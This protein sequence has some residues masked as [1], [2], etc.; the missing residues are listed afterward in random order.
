MATQNERVHLVAEAY[1]TSPSTKDYEIR[2]TKITPVC[3]DGVIQGFEQCD[4]QSSADPGCSASCTIEAG[5][6]CWGVPST[7]IPL[8][9]TGSADSCTEPGVSTGGSIVAVGTDF[10]ADFSDTLDLG[11]TGCTT[12]SGS[13]EAVFEVAR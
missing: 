8:S 5:Y 1:S 13:P 7:C 10:F 11:G 3:G 2:V 4:D 12:R 6:Q 9:Y